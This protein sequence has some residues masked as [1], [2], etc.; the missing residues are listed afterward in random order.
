MAMFFA[1]V[2]ALDATIVRFDTSA[3]SIDVR[4]YDTATPLSVDNLLNYA[5]SDR[6]DGTFIHRNAITQVS[7]NVFEPFVIQGGGFLLNGSIF[8]AEL[9]EQDATIMNEPGISNLRGTIAYA[10][11][12]DPN[13]AT[14]QWF[15]NLRDN[16]GLDSVANG[17]FTVFGRVIRG[18][19]DV[20]DA[21]AALPNINAAVAETP[22]TP[23]DFDEVPVFDA[24]KV[25]DQ[26]DIRSDDAVIIHSLDVLD[27]A[28]G[29]YNFDGA[30]TTADFIVWRNS[31]GSTLLAE[32]DG[33]GDG[34]VNDADYDVWRDSFG[35]S[36]SS[37][38]AATA[39]VPEP[40]AAVIL[41]VGIGP[42]SLVRF[43]RGRF[44]GPGKTSIA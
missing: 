42:L 25:L 12:S 10:K 7:T 19:M 44:S 38:S 34:V 41:M 16:T 9:I 32:A 15:F 27:F 35:E 28:D 24:D 1:P 43:G 11:G 30:V 36:T 17:A 26:G 3:G 31:L 14:S 13:S 22:S 29:D 37:E 2:A 6:Y 20:V 18:T 21:I 39:G 40:G 23:E 33:N 5:T 4:L 8:D